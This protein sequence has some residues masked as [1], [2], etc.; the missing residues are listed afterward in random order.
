MIKNARYRRILAAGLILLGAVMML[1]APASSTD[2]WIGLVF[3]SLGL[4][5]EIIGITIAHR[6]AKP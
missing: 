6:A 5:L 1:F 2:V 4:L 3:V